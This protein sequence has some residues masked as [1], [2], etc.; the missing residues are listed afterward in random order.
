MLV[1]GQLYLSNRSM[2]EIAS[3]LSDRLNSLKEDSQNLK[4]DLEYLEIPD[5]LEKE[6]R[7]RFNYKNPGEKLIIVVPA[8]NSTSTQ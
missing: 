1:S 3:A 7:S 2:S 8:S 5:N 4:S 6:L